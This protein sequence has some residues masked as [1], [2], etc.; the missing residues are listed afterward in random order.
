MNELELNNENSTVYDIVEV[1]ADNFIEAVVEK[2]KQVPVMIDFWAPWC[3]PCRNLTPILEELARE[4]NGAFQLAKVNIDDEQHLAAQFGVQSVPT[5][6]MVVNGEVVDGFMGAQPKNIVQEFLSKH[7]TPSIIQEDGPPAQEQKQGGKE[8]SLL[9]L[10]EKQLREGLLDEAQDTL[11]KFE[12]NK[13]DPQYK[14]LNAGVELTRELKNCKESEQELRAI[15]ERSSN[16]SNARYK[17][18]ILNFFQGDIE[19]ALEGFLNIV[20]ND[21]SFNDDAGRRGMVL[22][23]DALGPN[24]ELVG[25]YRNLLARTLH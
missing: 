15:L 12:D 9:A 21:R 8:N 23:F 18:S 2:S 14:S 5:V 25:K 1:T 3:G 7:V 24:H 13:Q 11:S 4:H 6:F 17:L 10:A 20:K 22:V 16:D 19:A